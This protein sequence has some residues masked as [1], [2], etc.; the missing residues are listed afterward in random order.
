MANA[1]RRYRPQQPL[2]LPPIPSILLLLFILAFL[3][4]FFIALF[5]HLSSSQSPN[6]NPNPDPQFL[7][8]APSLSPF[9]CFSSPQASPIIANLVE[10]VPYPFLISL[11]DFGS[12]PDKPHKNIVRT[13]KGKRFRKPDISETVQRVLEG[14]KG[15]DGVVVDVGGNVGM[16]AFAAAVMGFR[17]VCFEPVVENLQRICDGVWFNRIAGRVMVFEAVA[18][19]KRGNITFHKL[20][21]RLDNSAVSAAGAKLAFKSNEEVA[22]QVRSIPLDDVIPDTL[23]VLL[24]KI[25]VQGWEY[26]VL[27]GASKI[28]SRKAGKAPYLIYEEDERLLQASNTSA[29]EIRDFLRT[30]GYNH[31]TQHGTDAHC[32]KTA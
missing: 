19:D 18:S 10:G 25:D 5:S 27:K 15:E 28:L 9:D 26:H 22:L 13:L 11:S 32:T 12:L 29:K 8:L 30:K 6:P 2:S 3:I 23:P 16:A 14:R 4:I 1:W 20:V 24:I 31:C 7:S 21:G 17:V